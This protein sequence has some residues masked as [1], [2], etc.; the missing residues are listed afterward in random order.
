MK[1]FK[2]DYPYLNE[3]PLLVRTLETII[4]TFCVLIFPALISAAI[5]LLW[6]L[7][8]YK[9]GVHFDDGME[10]IVTASWIP[11]FGILYSL[12]TAIV[13]SSV[14]SEY[15]T[16]RLAVKQWDIDT[17]MDLRDE[18]M[19]PLVHAMVL[20][21]SIALLL[22]FM[23]LSYPSFLNGMILVASTA[24]LL[25]LIFMVIIEIDN[26][27][28]GFWFIRSIPEEWLVIDPKDWRA[29]RSEEIKQKFLAR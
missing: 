16:I 14:W 8:F 21:F 2:T 6:A 23:V 18:E 12:F 15:K 22:A 4:K 10:I 19:S 25:S 26:P 5:T 28:S 24:Y 29:K 7:F 9:N 27:C 1:I 13:L 3:Y 20:T 11:V 17:F